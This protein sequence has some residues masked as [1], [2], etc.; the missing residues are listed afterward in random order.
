M[1]HDIFRY[2]GSYTSLSLLIT[3]NPMTLQ[4]FFDWDKD[5]VHTESSSFRPHNDDT[6]TSLSRHLINHMLLRSWLQTLTLHN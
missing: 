6:T 1:D 5:D 4:K 2:R 3:T